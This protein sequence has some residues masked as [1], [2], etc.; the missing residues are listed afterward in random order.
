MAE[1]CEPSPD[2]LAQGEALYAADSAAALGVLG[3]QSETLE[4]YE[5]R[6]R[7]GRPLPAWSEL[8]AFTRIRDTPRGSADLAAYARRGLDFAQKLLDKIGTQLKEALCSEGKVRK[9]ILE[10]E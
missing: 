8:D 6:K 2:L 5:H 9:E 3:V 4:I 10:L 1:Y 7:D